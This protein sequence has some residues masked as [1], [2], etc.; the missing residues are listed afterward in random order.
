[1]KA[2]H[3]PKNKVIGPAIPKKI[4][5]DFR[6]LRES[7]WAIP[8]FAVIYVG[9]LLGAIGSHTIELP[10][11]DSSKLSGVNST[12][13][14]G[15]K[16][17]DQNAATVPVIKNHELDPTDRRQF[18]QMLL[19]RS[20]IEDGESYNSISLK[21]VLKDQQQE[22]PFTL[23]KLRPNKMLIKATL[24]GQQLR[25]VHNAESNWELTNPSSEHEETEALV[26]PLLAYIEQLAPFSDPLLEITTDS[27]ERIQT[28][29]WDTW[30]GAPA[31]RL[32]LSGGQQE[33]S[34]YT[35]YLEPGTLKPLSLITQ[36][37]SRSLEK[38]VFSNLDAD[39]SDHIFET[40]EFWHGD[41]RMLEI[42]V[43][44]STKNRGLLSILF[45]TP[46]T[47]RM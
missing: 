19:S 2:P 6:N 42:N 28:V 10:A 5:F 1:M 45:E 36:A 16:S 43:H 37:D 35:Y 7:R 17:S 27:L 26:R 25:F 18:L 11:R 44:Q 13:T 38:T 46:S 9:I 8:T 40:V 47:T 3:Y 24:A 22:V 29:E 4:S 21:G 15:D 31:I 41:N 32:E 33:R 20:S 34:R 12:V 30:S 23:I 14:N 39:I